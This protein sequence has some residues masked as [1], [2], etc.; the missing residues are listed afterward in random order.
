L[1]TIGDHKVSRTEPDRDK[2]YVN[3]VE[4]D[5]EPRGG[6]KSFPSRSLSSKERVLP[7]GQMSTETTC[8]A[9]FSGRSNSVHGSSKKISK[10]TSHNFW[11]DES[12]GDLNLDLG[13]KGVSETAAGREKEGT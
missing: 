9:S 13:K 10:S 6:S 2:L 7:M 12:S 5:G 3:G 4:P 1:G 8:R 11:E